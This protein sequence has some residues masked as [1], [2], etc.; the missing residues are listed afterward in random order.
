MMEY[1]KQ[2]FE[3]RDQQR[4]DDLENQKVVNQKFQEKF[5]RTKSIG[6]DNNDKITLL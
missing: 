5:T 2:Q 3:W 1:A 6:L 4:L